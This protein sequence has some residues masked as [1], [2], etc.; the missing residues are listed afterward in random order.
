M[1]KPEGTNRSI[2]VEY[3]GTIR[4]GEHL[5]HFLTADQAPLDLARQGP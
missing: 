4:T 2:E 3:C 5:E 1:V